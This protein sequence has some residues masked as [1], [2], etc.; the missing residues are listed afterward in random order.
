MLELEAFGLEALKVILHYAR[1][2]TICAL[3]F[4]DFLKMCYGILMLPE[5]WNRD[6]E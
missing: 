3:S 6:I 4:M 5:R 2:K 1:L